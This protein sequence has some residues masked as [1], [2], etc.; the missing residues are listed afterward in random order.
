MGRTIAKHFFHPYEVDKKKDEIHLKNWNDSNS[1][2]YFGQIPI[3]LNK[4]YRS[5]DINLE[6]ECCSIIPIKQCLPQIVVLDSYLQKVIEHIKNSKL[7]ESVKYHF[8]YDELSELLNLI[9]SS[10]YFMYYLH[11]PKKND[12]I[13][14]AEGRFFTLEEIEK[15]PDEKILNKIMAFVKNKKIDYMDFLEEW[16]GLI[17]HLIAEFLLFEQKVKIIFYSCDKC[18]RPGIFIKEKITK[19]EDEDIN[20]IWGTIN[21]VDTIIY[22]CTNELNFSKICQNKQRS[23]NNIIYHDESFVKRYD[24]VSKD[25]EI[26]K[27]ETDGAFILTTDEIIFE[28]LIKEI[29]S[30]SSNNNNQNFKFDLIVTGSTAEK[31]FKKIN[32]LNADKYIDRVCIYSI[33]IKKYRNLMDKY[34]KIEGIYNRVSQ[35]INF[36]NSNKEVSIIYPTIDLLTYKEYIDK[37]QIL[38]KLIS[39]HYG[40]NDDNC[41]KVA[42]SYLK[43]FLFWYPQLRVTQSE[44]KKIKIDT[45]LETLQKFQGINDNETDIIKLYTDEYDSFYKDFN[46]WLNSSDPLAIQKTSWFI[47]A[48]IYSLNKYGE[49]KG[50]TK[51]SKLYR[52]IKSNLSDLLVYER[53]KGKLICFPSFTSTTSIKNIAVNFSKRKNPEQYE[54]IIIIDYIYKNGFIPTAVDVSKI[55]KFEYEKEC[56]FPPYSFFKVK[57]TKIDYSLKTAEIK[58]ETVGRKKILE[59]FLKD[60]STLVYKEEEGLMDIE[61]S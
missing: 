34:D 49:E 46:Y 25:C 42:I 1:P 52:G 35:V 10:K 14:F 58:L 21:I 32:N 47:A 60:G 18:Y 29:I 22:N 54:T 6:K 24:E 19:E 9:K 36:I 45:L 7:Y 30:K 40:Q 28:S 23:K 56:L 51:T 41:F 61:P 3:Y 13:W 27:N 33:S 26:F 38:H 4:V 11:T 2:F 37:N 53:A 57:D 20:K 12:G 59:D 48:V 55:S 17:F 8:K 43:D 16:V 15:T 50:L 5:V 39:S 31:I 44:L